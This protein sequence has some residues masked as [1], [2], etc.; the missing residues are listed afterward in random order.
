MSGRVME[1]INY[2]LANLIFLRLRIIADK[3]IS[4]IIKINSYICVYICIYDNSKRILK[5]IFLK[6]TFPLPAFTNS[7][8][9]VKS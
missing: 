6:V 2:S 1:T 7:Q 4:Y 8:I 9:D 5:R 3:Y